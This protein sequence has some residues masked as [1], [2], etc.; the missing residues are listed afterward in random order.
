MA[1]LGFTLR[2]YAP[3]D[4][5][6][7]IEL[8]QRTWQLAYP[9]I[10]FASGSTGGASAG[11]TSSCRS[12]RS[13]SPKRDRH[14]GRLR[15]RRSRDRL[16]RP[17]RGR[18]GSVGQGLATALWRKPSGCRPQASTCTSTR[19]MRA[20]SASTKSTAS[21]SPAKRQPAFRRAGLHDE[22]AAAARFILK[23]LQAHPVRLCSSIRSTMPVE[24]SGASA[25]GPAGWR[26]AQRAEAM[27]VS[28]EIAASRAAHRGRRPRQASRACPPPR[29]R[30]ASI[31]R[32]RSQD[33]TV[34]SRCAIT[35]VVRSCI[36]RSSASCTSVSLSASSE[37][38]ASSAGAA[39][40]R[41][42][43]RA[44]SRCA[45]AGRPTASCRAR[46]PACRNPAAGGG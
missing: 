10:D 19:T 31:T 36:R 9:Q 37:D 42:G 20:P 46:R 16:S 13:W 26:R 30:R 45:G 43:S 35:S 15:H 3:A 18:A 38:V 7:A 39:A 27:K 32:M 23:R 41:A 33:S 1:S 44:R 8:W 25:H 40:H 34:A 22:L 24:R 4:E 28:S 6:A 11:A 14:H 5:D 29:S 17:D 21:S 2:P 12:R